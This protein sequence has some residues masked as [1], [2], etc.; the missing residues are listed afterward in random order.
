MNFGSKLA[1]RKNLLGALCVGIDPHPQHLAKWNLPDN[2]VGLKEFS[3]S[4]LESI[5][6]KAAAIKPQSALFERHGSRGIGVLEEVLGYCREKQILTILDVKR[7][8]IG[9]TMKAYAQSFLSPGAALEAD[10]ITVSPFLGVGSLAPAFALAQE[11]GKGIFVLALTSNPEGMSI[12]HAC[13]SKGQSV[14]ALIASEV[15]AYND[16]Y[17][18][19]EPGS[20]GLVV[21]ATIGSAIRDQKVKLDKFTGPLLAPGVGA[22]GAGKAEI[23]D[24][25]ATSKPSVL[26]SVSRSISQCGPEISNLKQAFAETLNEVNLALE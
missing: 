26:A 12:Q 14:A 3:F 20:F 8:D 21:G 13:T 16:F 11:A 6:D 23:E 18:P 25:F 17:F 7:G 9:S 10:A 2:E 19:E 1:Q 15:Q 22:Q 24:V 5:G 4:L